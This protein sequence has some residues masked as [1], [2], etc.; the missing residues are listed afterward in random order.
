MLSGVDPMQTGARCA[1]NDRKLG[2]SIACVPAS[3]P[4]V[5]KFGR[6]VMVLS[7]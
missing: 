2:I 4:Q 3:F 5:L 7:L 1:G 6:E